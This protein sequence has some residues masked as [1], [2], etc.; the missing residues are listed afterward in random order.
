MKMLMWRET[1]VYYLLD[2]WIFDC[3]FFQIDGCNLCAAFRFL[4]LLN[5][6]GPWHGLLHVLRQR[7]QTDK[8]WTCI[9]L[10]M[11]SLVTTVAGNILSA[12]F[13]LST[14]RTCRSAAVRTGTPGL[15]RMNPFHVTPG[16]LSL[17]WMLRRTDVSYVMCVEAFLLNGTCM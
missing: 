14:E 12:V 17:S 8:P 4:A 13:R 5:T 6:L 2:S 9:N 10:H 11:D 7:T 15:S 16:W 1:N 3:H